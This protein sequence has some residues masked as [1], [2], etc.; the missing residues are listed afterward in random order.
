MAANI[1]SEVVDLRKQISS[2]EREIG[3]ALNDLAKIKVEMGNFS[4]AETDLNEALSISRKI[5]H[6]E[7]IAANTGSLAEL[8]LHKQNW[9]KA[10]MLAQKALEIA[11][12]NGLLSTIA[13]NCH[14]IAKVFLYQKLPDNGL[15]YARRAL[16]IFVQLGSPNISE[17]EQ[18]L[19]AIE[20]EI[21]DNYIATKS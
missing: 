3:V 18:T 13:I 14:R 17:A 10:K 8:E 4:G 9:A 2:R 6:V 1:L 11:E 12:S 16:D 15:P 21:K 5:N 19:L 7:D 20:K